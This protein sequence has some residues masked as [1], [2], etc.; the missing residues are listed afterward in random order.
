MLAL[1]KQDLPLRNWKF[2]KRSFRAWS[3]ESLPSMR[4]LCRN[5]SASTG[6]TWCIIIVGKSNKR[7]HNAGNLH[8]I[9]RSSTL[10]TCTSRENNVSTIV[11]EDTS[12]RGIRISEV[13]LVKNILKTAKLQHFTFRAKYSLP[14]SYSVNNEYGTH[15]VLFRVRVSKL[16]QKLDLIRHEYTK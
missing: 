9:W 8:A 6:E 10:S 4:I 12:L 14:V 11:K 16:A 7:K 13:L 15:N 5:F 2:P 3:T 1:N